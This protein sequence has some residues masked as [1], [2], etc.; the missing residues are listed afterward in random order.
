MPVIFMKPITNL[1]QPTEVVITEYIKRNINYF[2]CEIRIVYKSFFTSLDIEDF[3]QNYNKYN[4]ILFRYV[5][6]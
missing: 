3:I 5:N 1:T 4:L 6:T 2:K